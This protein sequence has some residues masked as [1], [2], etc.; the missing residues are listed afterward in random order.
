[1][2]LRNIISLMFKS[3]ARG[4]TDTVFF[5]SAHSIRKYTA[6]M[7]KTTPLCFWAEL[8]DAGALLSYT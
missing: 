8:K 1:M 5:R 6:V 3:K 2:S 7:Q 4:T